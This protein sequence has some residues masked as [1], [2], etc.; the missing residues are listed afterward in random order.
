MTQV[1]YV[2]NYY[3]PGLRNRLFNISF[4]LL[5][6]PKTKD[7]IFESFSDITFRSKFILRF[8]L[9][10]ELW[11]SEIFRYEKTPP[12]PPH[13]GSLNKHVYRVL[14]WSGYV[15]RHVPPSVVRKTGV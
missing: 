14:L 10:K 5:P 9:S 13:N 2:I 4:P 15:C 7:L 12:S 8:N 3:F 1:E 6:S 11:K